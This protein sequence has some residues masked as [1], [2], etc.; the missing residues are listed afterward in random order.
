MTKQQLQEYYWLK[1]NIKK[2][3]EKLLELETEA[4]RV[5]TVYTKT[6]SSGKGSSKDRLGEIV[7]KIVDVQDQ[8]NELTVKAYEQAMAIEK[9]I[10]ALPNRERYLIRLRYI[11]SLSWYEIMD[12][13]HYSWKQVH[14]IHAEALRLLAE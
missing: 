7:A 1:K 6:K 4:K 11:D 14:R 5:T 9:A 13:M 10:I 8:I 3:E 2:L 12:E